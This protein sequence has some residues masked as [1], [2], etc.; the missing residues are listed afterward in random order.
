MKNYWLSKILSNKS[1]KTLLSSTLAF[2]LVFNTFSPFFAFADEITDTPNEV[3]AHIETGDALSAVSQES[4][5]N[6]NIITT[7]TES[8]LPEDLN[9]NNETQTSTEAVSNTETEENSDNETNDNSSITTS[10]PI[11]NIETENIATSTSE[12]TST[13][14]TGDN[15]TES[16]NFITETGDAVA[17]V[18]LV[19]VVNTNIVNSTG[20]IDFVQEM[21]GY[22]NFDMR[23]TFSDIFDSTTAISTPSCDQDICNPNEIF[24]DMV[25]QANIDNNVTVIA[26]TGNNSSSNGSGSIITGDAYASA[27]IVNL[28]NTNI[29]DS[30]YLLLVFNNFADMAGSLV[31]P[32]SDFF[33][34][35]FTQKSNQLGTL[36]SDNL[37]E[38]SNNVT[39]V[40]DTGNNSIS[41]D[42]TNTI[43]TGNSV[44]TSYIDNSI[45]QNFFNTNSFSMLIRVQGDW[46]GNIFGLPDGMQWENTS[47]GIRL[48]YS[49]E[50]TDDSSSSAF[51]NI[52]NDA[53]ITNNVQVYALTGDNEIDNGSGEIITGNAYSDST[54][55]N[56]ANN[57]IVGTNWANL[58]F[59]IY[60]DWNGDIAFGQPDLWLGLSI[61]NS[62]KKIMRPGEGLSY[63]YTIFNRG[64]VTA[65]NVILENEFPITSL[66][67][68]KGPIDKDNLDG[69]TTWNLGNIKAGETKEF[70]VPARILPSFATNKQLPLPLNSIVYSDQPDG[71]NSDNS[72]T[73]MLYVGSKSNNKQDTSSKTFPAQISLEKTA[74]KAFAKAGDTIN[75]SVKVTSHGGPV[76][77]ALL[78]DTLKD[79]TGNILSEQ[80]WPLETI[81]SGETINITYSINLP[82]NIKNGIYTN[83]AQLVGLHGSKS[84]KEKK[85][86]ESA[87]A[88]HKLSVGLATESQML[89][90]N[91]TIPTCSPYLTAY[92]RQGYDNNPS[93]VIKLQKFLK[94]HVSSEVLVT[95]IFDNTTRVA[96]ENFQQQYK[97]D[98]LTPWNMTISSGYVYY[99][100]KKKINEI[101]CEGKTNFPLTEE[102]ETEIEYFKLHKNNSPEELLFSAIPNPD[103]DQIVIETD[104]NGNESVT[105][106]ELDNNYQIPLLSN[107]L[108]SDISYVRLSN[109]LYLFQ[110]PETAFLHR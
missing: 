15:T 65:K 50:K 75:Y 43:I 24:V 101:M 32:N 46:T 87:I 41:S 72:D 9:L 64:D 25:N 28:A 13:A 83:S 5:I 53:T 17:Y 7:E 21:L 99:T 10:E 2:A 31:L 100:T 97:E 98:I 82:A 22:E 8:T 95:G 81:K 51:T 71:N 14:V 110:N 60:G 38:I 62:N 39:T 36:N 49:P 91:N 84:S 11:I 89:N 42:G 92:L 67:F 66:D 19:N 93:E 29:V 3:V 79:E 45:N 44:S 55:F 35:Y 16:G 78:V 106:L 102:Q 48:Y 108:N 47:Q 85:P 37:A 94:E 34:S 86:Y 96:V 52:T 12:V 4:N 105:A 57:N 63:T 70:T 59:N 1:I 80:T 77:D 103:P 73:L 74:D 68:S 18:D 23:D 40:A 104:N 90:Y 109:W 56:I 54:I 58:I 76:F 26:D 20:L 61:Q 33:Q 69:K 6:T 88:E 27:N 30:N 107:T